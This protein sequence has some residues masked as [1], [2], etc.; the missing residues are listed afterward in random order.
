[1]I[2]QSISVI[3]YNF[4]NFENDKSAFTNVAAKENK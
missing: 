1:M 3:S 4:I 2:D